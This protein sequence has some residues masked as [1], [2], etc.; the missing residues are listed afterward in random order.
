MPN[1]CYTLVRW[2]NSIKVGTCLFLIK[3][4]VCQVILLAISFNLWPQWLSF[5][6]L[7]GSPYSSGV[8]GWF[9]ALSLF[10]DIAA[11][12]YRRSV[13]ACV[14]LM[15]G[16]LYLGRCQFL[17]QILCPCEDK[18]HYFR[19]RLSVILSSEVTNRKP[20]S[21]WSDFT[22]MLHNDTTKTIEGPVKEALLYM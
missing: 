15:N 17:N 22:V 2:V 16:R 6:R 18:I 11:C 4:T 5:T 21:K 7:L 10:T 12:I 14:S 3:W 9:A 13:Y 20:L 19:C 1:R 8:R